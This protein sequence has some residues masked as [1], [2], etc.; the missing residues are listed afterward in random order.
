MKY[1]AL[2]VVGVLTHM[3][4]VTL[5]LKVSKFFKSEQVEVH[6][7]FLEPVNLQ[8]RLAVFNFLPIFSLICS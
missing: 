5:G 1:S 8:F 3:L 7:S 4:T 2:E 6:S